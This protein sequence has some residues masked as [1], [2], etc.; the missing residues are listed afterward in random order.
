MLAASALHPRSPQPCGKGHG[1]KE[2]CAG[3][4]MPCK[5]EMGRVST[6]Q[7]AS[8]LSYMRDSPCLFLCLL[9][10]AGHLVIEEA[11]RST[12]FSKTHPVYSSYWAGRPLLEDSSMPS[13][14][15]VW[16]FLT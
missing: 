13:P 9:H 6:L 8:S 5:A 10:S 2:I 7:A 14:Y 1:V 16:L 15:L 11:C 4:L 3:A 12:S